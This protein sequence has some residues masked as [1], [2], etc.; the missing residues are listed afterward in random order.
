MN[1]PPLSI[2]GSVNCV[3]VGRA[4]LAYYNQKN[5]ISRKVYRKWE[6]PLKNPVSLTALTTVHFL[7]NLRLKTGGLAGWGMKL[8]LMHRS[9]SMSQASTL[10]SAS[11]GELPHFNITILKV[12]TTSPFDT[13]NRGTLFF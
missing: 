1:T 6:F 4:L 2:K 5:G 12:S 9:F 11:A 10:Q 7:K 8:R 13:S 3:W